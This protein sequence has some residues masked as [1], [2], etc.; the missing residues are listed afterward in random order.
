M[1]KTARTTIAFILTA[2]IG[3]S[4]CGNST[5]ASNGSN[6]NNPSVTATDASSSTTETVEAENI[7]NSFD[8]DAYI[9]NYTPKT[10]LTNNGLFDYEVKINGAVLTC[11]ISTAEIAA[12]GYETKE[13]YTVEVEPNK[14][15]TLNGSKHYYINK[16]TG[17]GLVL[18]SLSTTSNEAFI[19]DSDMPRDDVLFYHL[20]VN[21]N[22]PHWEHNKSFT[23]DFYGGT[24]TNYDSQYNSE[25]EILTSETDLVNKCGDCNEKNRGTRYYYE[26][27]NTDRPRDN[28]VTIM[29][30]D[31]N[32]VFS[33]TFTHLLDTEESNIKAKNKK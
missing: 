15:S 8:I 19:Y 6:S 23:V 25:T 17:V 28:M 27:P 2:A 1:K 21:T 20:S 18:N 30:N 4:G 33:L 10:E 9:A 13:A 29:L 32:N 14:R 11:P 5:T 31:S 3:M 22:E 26:F 16:E 7:N 12:L 24:V